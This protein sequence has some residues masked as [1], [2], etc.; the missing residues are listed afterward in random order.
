MPSRSAASELAARL[1]Q[2]DEPDA[3]D[4]A[5]PLEVGLQP[6]I[7]DRLH[8][9][10]GLAD[11]EGEEDDRQLDRPEVEPDEEDGL[12]RDDGLGDELRGVE[13]EPLV[14]VRRRDARVA[15][16]LDVVARRVAERRAD[17]PLE[18]A[19]VGRRGPHARAAAPGRRERLAD[20]PQVPA[21]L[22]GTTG[23]QP[24]PQVAGQLREP[25]ERALRQPAG[26]PRRGEHQAP[27]ERSARRLEPVGL[28]ARPGPLAAV[29]DPAARPAS[30]RPSL[31]IGGFLGR[32]PARSA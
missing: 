5:R 6:R 14:D 9:R 17:E 27:T 10:H 16:D 13:Q 4:A 30:P 26:Q 28:V 22:G 3:G 31:E 23:R 18:G 24:V 12:A 21:R 2:A 29:R 25:E 8:R 11:L 1:A 7:V 20:A 32:R 19:R 15:G